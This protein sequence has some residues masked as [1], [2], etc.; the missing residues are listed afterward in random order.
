MHLV[1]SGGEE[2][3]SCSIHDSIDSYTPPATGVDH[4]EQVF[5]RTDRLAVGNIGPGAWKYLGT[6]VGSLKVNISLKNKPYLTGIE[7]NIGFVVKK[8]RLATLPAPTNYAAVNARPSLA[9]PTP[10]RSSQAPQT[11]PLPSPTLSTLHIPA[12]TCSPPSTSDSASLSSTTSTPS[13]S[14]PCAWS[15]AA[16]P[17]SPTCTSATTCSLTCPG[18]GRPFRTIAGS[19][20]LP[21]VWLEDRLQGDGSIGEDG[22]A[23]VRAVEGDAESRK[24][25]RVL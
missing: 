17:R 7:R 2:P 20:I 4:R 3:F 13:P 11:S 24:D 1:Q 8:L 12:E 10:L 19:S 15:P 21:W 5:S 14:P 9:L 16:S 18:R 25:L 6:Q 22:G 23:G